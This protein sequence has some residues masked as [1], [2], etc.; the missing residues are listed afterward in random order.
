M[1]DVTLFARALKAS[2]LPS[3]RQFSMHVLGV[4][5][6]TGRR[7]ESGESPMPGS[8]RSLCILYANGDVSQAAQRRLIEANGR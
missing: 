6:R 3:T 7:W 4:D 2:Q 1:D 8:A 5:E